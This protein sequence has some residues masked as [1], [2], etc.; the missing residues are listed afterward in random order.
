MQRGIRT[1]S[2]TGREEQPSLDTN[3]IP[4]AKFGEGYS[5]WG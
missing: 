1:L 4:V 3:S 5:L 2:L